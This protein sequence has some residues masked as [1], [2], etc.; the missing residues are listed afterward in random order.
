MTDELSA[1]LL[2]MGFL[3]RVAEKS[4]A[5]LPTSGTQQAL[6]T[7]TG[8]RV[9]ITQIFGECTTVCSGTATNIKLV[10]NPTTGTDVDLCAAA[11][12]TSKEVG[13]LVGP[14]GLNTDA[15]HVLNAG[16][17]PAQVRG[18]I[19]NKGTVDVHASATNTGA[20]KWWASWIPLD[21]GAELVG[22]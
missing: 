20:F 19:V 17:V 3:G 18:I 6:F 7:V 16:G 13:T 5:V 11:A 14:S 8:G 12:I 4:A 10:G 1:A 22:G 9:L 15:L 21:D 2:R